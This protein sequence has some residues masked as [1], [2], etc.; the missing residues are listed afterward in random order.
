[1]VEVDKVH[2]LLSNMDD[3]LVVRRQRWQTLYPD[4]DTQ[5]IS[6]SGKVPTC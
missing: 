1:M 2:W 3:Q 5:D 6:R 4:L